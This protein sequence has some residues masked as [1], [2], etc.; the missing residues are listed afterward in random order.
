MAL[1]EG[2][3]SLFDVSE[4]TK[5]HAIFNYAKML[6]D[7]QEKLANYQ[8]YIEELKSKLTKASDSNA[9]RDEQLNAKKKNAPHQ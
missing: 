1:E 9:L 4:E 3:S 8:R 5:V 2:K 7:K 6:Q